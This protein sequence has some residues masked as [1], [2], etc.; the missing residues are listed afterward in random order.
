MKATIEW[1]LSFSGVPT[2]QSNF[3]YLSCSCRPES[4]E[5]QLPLLAA[6][7]ACQFSSSIASLILPSGKFRTALPSPLPVSFLK[8]SKRNHSSRRGT[9]QGEIIYALPPLPHILGQKTCLRGKRGWASPAAGILYPPPNFIHHPPL[10]GYF[11][12]WGEEVYKNLAPQW[13][14]T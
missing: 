4:E 13:Y 14:P 1:P 8:T 12:G 2:W 6:R 10:E 11:Q 7:F 5:L 9:S 3:L